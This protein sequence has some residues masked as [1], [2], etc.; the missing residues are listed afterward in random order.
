MRCTKSQQPG[1]TLIELIVSIMLLGLLAAIITP[2][3]FDSAARR[4]AACALEVKNLVSVAAH[5]DSIGADRLALEY[6]G[7]ARLL[8]MLVL[9]AGAD[10][11][12]DVVWRPDPL[13][14][15]VGIASGAALTA[16]ADGRQLDPTGWRITMPTSEPRPTLELRLALESARSEGWAVML[17]PGASS[18]KLRAPGAGFSPALRSIDLDL[19]GTGD[20][21]W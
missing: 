3:F 17:F 6:D 11:T 12:Q 9:R 14:N 7:R 8:R 2:R 19:D 13:V 15:D 1:F 10:G 16:Y 4:A 21:P 20:R 5:R 18:A